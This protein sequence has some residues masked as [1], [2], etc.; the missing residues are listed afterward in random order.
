MKIQHGEFTH[1]QLTSSWEKVI[2]SQ[3][4][5][6][7]ILYK[8]FLHKQGKETIKTAQM[9]HTPHFHNYPQHTTVHCHTQ[10]H[11]TDT[12]I[13]NNYQVS[14]LFCRMS[15][16]GLSCLNWLLGSIFLIT[17]CD[18]ELDYDTNT[19]QEI[20]FNPNSG[21]LFEKKSLMY[22]SNKKWEHIFKF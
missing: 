18:G 2:S 20:V 21:V 8:I 5:M 4:E 17:F 15:R 14:V 22:L 19:N 6:T 3:N 16:Y 7:V 10:T 11:S 1:R 13:F 12:D 9:L